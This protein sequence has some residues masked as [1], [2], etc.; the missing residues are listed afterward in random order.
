VLVGGTFWQTAA[1][2]ADPLIDPHYRLRTLCHCVPGHWMIEGIGFFNGLALRWFRD[3]FCQEEVA[4]ARQHGDD[5]YTWMERRA[6]EVPPGAHGLLAIFS[7]A[8]NARHWKHA[9]PSFVQFDIHSPATSGKKECIRALMESA[10]YVSLANYQ[11][12]VEVTGLTPAALTLCGGAAKGTVWPQI[13]ADVHGLPVHIPITPESTALGGAMC[14]AVGS[15]VYTDL[16]TAA[17]EMMHWDRTV[18]PN[19]AASAMYETTYAH[20]RRVYP[21][22][23]ALVEDGL[24]Q[25]MWQAPGT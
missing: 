7:D 9:A 25:P 11:M 21:R 8:M 15:G 1:V 24:L 14:V 16:T 10:A 17:R 4:L 6:A 23:L 22:L 12:L 2:V 3:A 18:E 20:W 19:R 13:V 5:P